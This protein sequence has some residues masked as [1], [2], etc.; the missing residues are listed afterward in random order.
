MCL[1]A[2]A[3]DAHPHYALVLAANR[4]E[5]HHRPTAAADFWMDTPQIFGGRDLQGHG[6]W[7]AVTRRGRWA[8]VTNVRRMVPPDPAAP[9]RGQLVS[10]F[11]Q[12]PES[13][14]NHAEMLRARVTDYAGF[15]LLLGEGR[16]VRYVSNHAAGGVAAV[17]QPIGNGIHAVSN[18]A[19]DTPWPKL[20]SLRAQMQQWCQAGERDLRPLQAALQDDVQAADE[21]LP[22]TGVGLA[23][24]RFLSPIFIRGRDYGTRASTILTISHKGVLSFDEWRWGA[25]GTSQGHTHQSWALDPVN[26]S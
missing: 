21:A 16:V 15:N 2:L 19:L 25:Q 13:A 18:D 10:D 12:S 5:F 9:S 26:P 17:L 14:A 1:I 3:L 20:C 8:A 24:E 23:M 4:D 22:Q 7:L 11:L 6:T